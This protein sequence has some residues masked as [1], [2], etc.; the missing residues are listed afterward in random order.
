M[1]A[2]SIRAH[3]QQMSSG[4]CVVVGEI[5]VA[6][7]TSERLLLMCIQVQPGNPIMGAAA[8]AAASWCNTDDI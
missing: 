5:Q 7:P 4:V 6:T 2:N 8:T 1:P 3:P